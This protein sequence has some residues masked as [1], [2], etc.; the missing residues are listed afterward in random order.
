[1]IGYF[2][3]SYLEGGRNEARLKRGQGW[4]IA[5]STVAVEDIRSQ[6]LEPANVSLHGKLAFAHV[7]K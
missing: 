4:G 5:G 2:N 3:N 6:S 1:M 7:I